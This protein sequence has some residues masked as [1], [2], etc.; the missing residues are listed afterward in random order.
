MAN[1]SRG[2]MKMSTEHLEKFEPITTPVAE[3]AGVP[4]ETLKDLKGVQHLEKFDDSK[5]LILASAG[6]SMDLK[7]IPLP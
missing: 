7:T 3:T 5:A 6:S 4:Y 2:V 1:S